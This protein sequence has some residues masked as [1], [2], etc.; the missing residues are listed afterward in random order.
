[1]ANLADEIAYNNHD[2]DD[3]LRAGLI[4]IEQLC[5]VT[6]FRQQYEV[7]MKRYP[8]LAGRR[9]IHE[10]IRRMINSQVTDLINNARANLG[11]VQPESIDAVRAM[12]GALICFSD[13]MN[14][15]NLEMKRF[16]RRQLYQHYRVQ[17]MTTKA[18]RVIRELFDIFMAEP[19]LLPPEASREAN[20]FEEQ[21]GEEGRARAVADYIAGMTDRYAI[22]EY[23]RMF[24]PAALTW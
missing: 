2:V 15:F 9:R 13:E 5:E 18:G 12:D 1:L 11:R 10:I 21:R 17:R 3:G 14:E 23:G 24:D 19:K 16:L 7:V 8:D 22:R 20:A 4:T 6:L